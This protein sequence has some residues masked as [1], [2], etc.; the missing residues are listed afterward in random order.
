MNIDPYTL[1]QI[2]MLGLAIA[3]AIAGVVFASLGKKEKK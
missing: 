2:G 1:W 3:Y